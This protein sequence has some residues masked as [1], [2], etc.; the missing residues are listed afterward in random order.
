MSVAALNWTEAMAAFEH[1]LRSRGRAAAT[2]DAYRKALASFAGFYRGELGKPG[3]YVSRLQQTDLQTFV[4]HLR[5]GRGGRRALR[6]SSINRFVVALRAFSDFAVQ[7]RWLK[8]NVAL[9]LKTYR[10]PLPPKAPRLSLTEIH[11]L[12][13][14]VVVDGRNGRRDIAI[15]NLFLHTGLRVGEL[16]KLDVGDVTLRNRSGSLRV[17][18]DKGR[19]ERFATLNASCRSTLRRYLDCR[20]EVDAAAPLFVSERGQRIGVVTVQH[21]IKRRLTC[22]GRDDLSVHSLRHHFASAL[23]EKTGNL[24]AVQEALGHRSVVTTAR[25]ARAT[26]QQIEEAVES[27]P[28]N[29]ATTQ[30]D[31]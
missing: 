28:G 9:D 12:L 31:D 10:A 20:G 8:R 19:A 30:G 11:R 22:A 26:A 7:Q 23:Y 29:I 13:A 2:V 27:L 16:S 4:D 25:Y 17:C 21:L 18:C 15:I 3:P 14:S 1:S 6:A 5:H 24:S